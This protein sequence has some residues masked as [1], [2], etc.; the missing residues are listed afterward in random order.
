VERERDAVGVGLG[1]LG[2]RAVEELVD[3]LV[4]EREPP[5]EVPLPQPDPGVQRRVGVERPARVAPGA[6]QDRR[7]E[8]RDDRDVLLEVELRD[9]GE[10]EADDRVVQRAAVERADQ[11]LAVVEVVDVRERRDGPNDAITARRPWRARRSPGVAGDAPG[12]GPMSPAA[13]GGLGCMSSSAQ[14]PTTLNNIGVAMFTVAD[15]DAAIA[16]YVE[17]LGFELRADVS[18]GEQGESRWVEVAP[19]GSTARLA[20]NPAMGPYTP[21]GSGIGVET[22]DVIGEHRRLSAIGG[23]DL[24]AEPMSVPGAPLL[25]MMR[26]PDG[27]HLAIVEAPPAA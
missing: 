9:V 12:P 14:S 2:A 17:K 20:L 10:D 11:P 7:P 3:G 13:R 23:I 6:E 18:F 1:L 24:D 22:A 15:Q 16:F 27:N 21:G 26:D 5:P 4:P 25:F 19:P 8:R